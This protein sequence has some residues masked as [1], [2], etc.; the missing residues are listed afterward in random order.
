MRGII[1]TGEVL[2]VEVC[3]DLCGA[4]I[5]MSQEFLYRPQVPAGLQHV[6]GKAVPQQV[7]IH[8]LR[9]ALSL[10]PV[11]DARLDRADRNGTPA[12]AYE[13]AGFVEAGK[14]PANAAPCSQGRSGV[15]AQRHNPG[16]VALAGHRDQT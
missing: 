10:R 12:I 13:Y 15:A 16:L 5:R 3:V 1:D 4:D 7:G 11:L 9:Q 8:R 6:T 14:L 2:E